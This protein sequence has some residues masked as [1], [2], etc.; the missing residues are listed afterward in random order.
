M[1]NQ[2][3]FEAGSRPT[4]RERVAALAGHSTFREPA[5]PGAVNAQRQIPTDHLIAA[6]L[7][8]GRTG[9]NDIGPDIAYDMATGRMGHHRRVC[10]ALGQA[11]ASER[12]RVVTRNRPYIAVV[13]WAGYS[14]V[15]GL[16]TVPRPDGCAQED[17][18]VLVPAAA[19][20]LE[21][22]AEDALSL[23]ARRARRTA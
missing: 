14:A 15:V 20:I 13:A 9:P 12:S 8:F 1:T 6:A 11:L 22:L 3:T 16:G 23:A 17:W 19:L 18:D 4:F 7:S 10:L 5:A 2:T 21:R